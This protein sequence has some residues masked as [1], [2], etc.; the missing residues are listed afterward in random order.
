MTEINKLGAEAYY[1]ELKSQ[2]LFGQSEVKVVSKMTQVCEDLT[3]EL[4]CLQEDYLD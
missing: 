1:H 4:E 3:H 2:G